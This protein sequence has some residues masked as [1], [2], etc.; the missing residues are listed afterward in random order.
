MNFILHYK[1]FQNTIKQFLNTTTKKPQRRCRQKQKRKPSAT[2]VL[3]S[4]DRLYLSGHEQKG[5]LHDAQAKRLHNQRT[6]TIIAIIPI[7]IHHPAHTGI[8][9]FA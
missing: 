8:P 1:L 2:P 4:S 9:F 7:D 5:E 6:I 3:S